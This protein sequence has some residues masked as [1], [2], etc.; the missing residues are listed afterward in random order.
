MRAAGR[1]AQQ[2]VVLFIALIILVA[3]SL[4]GVALI[5]SVDTGTVIA[6]NL[7]FRQSTTYVG[8]IGI[9]AARAWLKTRTP[10]QLQAQALTAGTTA[11]YA[12]WRDDI[13]LL[14]NEPYWS[15]GVPVNVTASP[16]TPPAGYTVRYV[17]N[18]LCAADGDPG[19]SGTNCVKTFGTAGGAS[20]GSKG[21]ATYGGY[22]LS[23]PVSAI[24]RVTV[25]VTGPRN[26]K[27]YIQTV[28]F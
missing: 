10:T 5:R 26:S 7:A 6:A 12:R 25:Q 19:V 2:G 9:E 1:R 18:R 13:T 22:A 21:A 14:G 24:Y 3:M 16:Y 4:A 8:D 20:T 23:S 15:S 11:Y 28:L 17:I 27:S